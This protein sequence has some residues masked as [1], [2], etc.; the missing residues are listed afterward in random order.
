MAIGSPL[1]SSRRFFVNGVYDDRLGVVAESEDDLATLKNSEPE[2]ATDGESGKTPWGDVAVFFL[3]PLGLY[4]MWKQPRAFASHMR[5]LAS[6][7]EKRAEPELTTAGGKGGS[8]WIGLT[9][10]LL[11]PLGLY[12]LLKQPRAFASHLRGLSAFVECENK[13]DTVKGDMRNLAVV[14]DGDGIKPLYVGLAIFLFFPVGLFL[15]WKH[16]RLSR[17]R[18]WWWGGGI[19]SF[20]YLMAMLNGDKN[21]QPSA[22]SPTVSRSAQA[23]PAEVAPKPIAHEQATSRKEEPT[24]QESISLVE[25]SKEVKKYKVSKGWVRSVAI[26]LPE[27]YDV[28]LEF[29]DFNY[30]D[31]SGQLEFTAVWNSHRSQEPMRRWEAFDSEGVVIDSG[32]LFFNSIRSFVPTRG[33]ITF[34]PDTWKNTKK[35]I[36]E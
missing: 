9:A 32:R 28:G 23:S 36:I 25:K 17:N 14:N 26:E 31:A 11:W 8:P 30:N 19:W 22:A 24:A 27:T 34:R 18:A 6:Y 10:F 21:N 35:L 3:W 2:L 1:W 4:L 13:L 29:K 15:L 7:S 12:L 16:P 33:H 20:I 5:G